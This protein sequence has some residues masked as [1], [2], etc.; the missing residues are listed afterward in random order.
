MPCSDMD[1]MEA[2]EVFKEQ[3]RVVWYNRTVTRKP[4]VLK[5]SCEIIYRTDEDGSQRFV[6]GAM[7]FNEHSVIHDVPESFS[8]FSREGEGDVEEAG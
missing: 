5:R 1:Q 7:D 2:L 3:S 4:I 8:R 6:V